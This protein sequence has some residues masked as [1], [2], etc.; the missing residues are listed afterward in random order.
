LR[1]DPCTAIAF[2]SVTD[3]DEEDVDKAIESA[4]E[5]FQSERKV[6]PHVRSTRLLA[7]F[8]AIQDS[9]DDLAKILTA[10]TGK[11]LKES[12]LEIDYGSSFLYWFAGEA[13]RIH[14]TT[15]RGALVRSTQIFSLQFKC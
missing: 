6:S 1:L 8:Q 9:K 10:E 13:E 2:I 11:P 7:W 12:Y 4:H 3:C 5:R 15:T 14:G